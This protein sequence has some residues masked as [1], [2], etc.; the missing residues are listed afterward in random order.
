MNT[1]TTTIIYSFLR[2]KNN[3]TKKRDCSIL[4]R[5]CTPRCL[6][7]SSPIIIIVITYIVSSDYHISPHIQIV[8]YS[9]YVKCGTKII[10]DCFQYVSDRH[11]HV[12]IGR[13]IFNCFRVGYRSNTAPSLYQC[14][15]LNTFLQIPQNRNDQLA[16]SLTIGSL[17]VK[18]IFQKKIFY[19]VCNFR[20]F[21][22]QTK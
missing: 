21:A 9:F 15:P 8:L 7:V 16:K 19:I 2:R 3:Q 10:F 20:V 13:V 1:R 18:I 6:S 22:F 17:T 4:F 14:G 5:S 11:F 12:H